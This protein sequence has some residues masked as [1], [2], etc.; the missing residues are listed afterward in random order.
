MMVG[1]SQI[2]A[3]DV[4]VW[5]HCLVDSNELWLLIITDTFVGLPSP[6]S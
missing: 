2:G 4:L 6:D 1:V 5:F 3:K